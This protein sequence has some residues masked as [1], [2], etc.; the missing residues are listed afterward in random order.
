MTIIFRKRNFFTE[1]KIYSHLT[2]DDL[3]AGLF[4]KARALIRGYRSDHPWLALDDEEL[5]KSSSLRVKD[6]A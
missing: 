2:M 5:L 3:D 4:G 1:S 6:F